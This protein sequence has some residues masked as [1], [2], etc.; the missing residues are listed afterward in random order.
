MLPLQ[1]S[2][3]VVSVMGT[4]ARRALTTG[5]L[6]VL[7]MAGA[8]PSRA[9]AQASGDDVAAA[10]RAYEQGLRAQL[11]R[12][13]AQAAELFELADRSAPSAPA[14]RSAIR[15]HE[16]AG[17][18]ARALTLATRALKRY[19]A[20]VETKKLADGVITRL[21]SSFGVLDVRCTPACALVLDG[22]VADEQA[23]V[24]EIFVPSGEHEI[25]GS[26]GDGHTT[27]RTIHASAGGHDELSLT[28]PVVA[29]AAA[30]SAPAAATLAPGARVITT[31]TT[32]AAPADRPS[33][34]RL[35]PIVAIA[36][37]ALTLGVAGALVWSGVD[38]LAA[39]DRYQKTPTESGYR[40][41][42]NRELRTN[43]LIGGVAL[44]GAATAVVAVFATDWHHGILGK[45]SP[46]AASLVPS[47]GVGPGQ[48]SV[49]LSGQ[50]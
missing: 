33:A 13:Y 11:R 40:D 8:S 27:A 41:G 14:L 35:P 15:N 37:G 5:A 25:V 9:A 1:V 43:L 23:S 4:G 30:P 10:A 42:T 17:N 31:P 48:A 16:T 6:A 39:R 47:A 45:R 34:R 18:S 3:F 38:T 46:R 49:G 12:D 20:D 32:A 29:D 24:H 7:L 2:G 19:P 36:G 21:A 50:F 28:P 22:R 44:L 26:F